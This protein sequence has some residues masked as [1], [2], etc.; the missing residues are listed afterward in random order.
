MVKILI[1]NQCFFLR[2]SG[3]KSSAF[4]VSFFGSIKKTCHAQQNLAVEGVGDLS[5]SVK[6]KNFFF[7][8]MLNKV[9]KGWIEVYIFFMKSF[10]CLSLN[11]FSIML[12]IR[13]RFT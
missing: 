2:I 4:I 11:F 1:Y 10:F 5:E 13:L 7:K 8:I 6:K 3:V 9:P 12:E